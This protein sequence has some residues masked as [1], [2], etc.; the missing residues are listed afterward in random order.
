MY[1]CTHNS[2]IE[3][4]LQRHENPQNNKDITNHHRVIQCCVCAH[5]CVCVDYDVVTIPKSLHYACTYVLMYV[6]KNWFPQQ[7]YNYLLSY[8][9]LETSVSVEIF[10]TQM[11]TY[12]ANSS[13]MSCV[14]LQVCPHITAITPAV[15]LKR[16]DTLHIRYML[17]LRTISIYGIVYI[18]IQMD[19]LTVLLFRR[20]SRSSFF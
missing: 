14:Y 1:T 17:L 7:Y 9:L 15:H 13:Q 3:T 16:Y 18:C 4:L 12:V 2:C 19:K 11:Y 8:Q 5:V 6:Q 20:Q 10:C